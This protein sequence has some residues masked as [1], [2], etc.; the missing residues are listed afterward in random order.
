M[1]PCG[2]C[3]LTKQQTNLMDQRE[4]LDFNEI[5]KENKVM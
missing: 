1:T 3:L 5:E 2:K 4:N